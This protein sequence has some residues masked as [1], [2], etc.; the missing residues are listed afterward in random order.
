MLNGL[1]SANL[2]VVLYCVRTGTMGQG[3]GS[4]MTLSSG[5][6]S[7]DPI[8]HGQ[9]GLK[10]DFFRAVAHAS[11]GPRAIYTSYE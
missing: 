6:V 2:L 7:T 1:N 9:A 8:I 4:D 11:T 10:L 5:R 3:P